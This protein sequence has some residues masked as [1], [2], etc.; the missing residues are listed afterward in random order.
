LKI[1]FCQ[2]CD[3]W[4]IEETE[5]YISGGTLMNNFDMRTF[6]EYHLE[7]DSDKIKWNDD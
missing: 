1:R 3:A 7:I 2:D 5:E 6:L 4:T